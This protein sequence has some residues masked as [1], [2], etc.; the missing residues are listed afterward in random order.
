MTH[1]TNRKDSQ[2]PEIYNDGRIRVYRNP[3]REIFVEDVRSGTTI[4]ISSYLGNGG[5]LQ[6][7]TDALVEPIRITNMIGWRVGP[8]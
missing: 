5:G 1:H 2:F 8:R 6:F 3:S 4:R 7:T